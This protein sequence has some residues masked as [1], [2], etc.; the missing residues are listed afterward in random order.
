MRKYH[1]ITRGILFLAFTFL[2]SYANAQAQCA[3][4]INSLPYVI[5][6]GYQ[7]YCLGNNLTYNATADNNL[8]GHY[9]IPDLAN[10]WA[11]I[12][13]INFTAAI[14]VAAPS[15]T[16][17]L[18]NRTLSATSLVPN[19]VAV[20]VYANNVSNFRLQNGTIKGFDT[21]AF[22]SSTNSIAVNRMVFDRI[23]L[24]A[25]SS[26]APQTNS[27]T[28]NTVTNFSSVS[29]WP[30]APV[31]VFY[32]GGAKNINDT[33]TITNNLITSAVGNIADDRDDDFS[34]VWG[35][36]GAYISAP[37]GLVNVSGNTFSNITANGGVSASLFFT[38]GQNPQ[39]TIRKN[40]FTFPLNHPSLFL[41]NVA[42]L[43]SGSGITKADSNFFSGF[44]TQFHS[45]NTGT[46]LIY[47]NNV[48][49]LY[50]ADGNYP[51]LFY[52]YT[53]PN[54]VDAGG[55]VIIRN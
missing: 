14:V 51:P 31:S 41:Q 21:G 39:I 15:V 28:N 30:M 37:K 38:G 46:P 26:Y 43:Q 23:K 8:L 24:Q 34:T 47:S 49:E 53:N 9:S 6:S 29:R 17:D 40:K 50:S 2:A 19:R 18:N 3:V 32:V 12:P 36:V 52:N 48:F 16:L 11:D 35:M 55:N 42:V 4:M 54:P 45:F 44:H 25:I 20:A 27:V 7:K 22:I 13:N 10:F 5:T 33:I 1:K